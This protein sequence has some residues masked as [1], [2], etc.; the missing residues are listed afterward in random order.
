MN[1][2]TIIIS[3]AP[4]HMLLTGF[5]LIM[6]WEMISKLHNN[7]QYQ[8]KKIFSII[9]NFMFKENIYFFQAISIVTISM[10]LALWSFSTNYIAEP[11][12]G[13][14]SVTPLTNLLVLI[15]L[16]L[17]IPSI[18]FA[19]N[20]HSSPRFYLL[21]IA[22]VYGAT[23]IPTADSFVSLFLSIEMTAIPVYALVIMPSNNGKLRLAAE[24]AL[25]Y[26]IIGSIATSTIL[27]GIAFF[28]GSNSS[29]S[30]ALGEF[31]SLANSLNSSS[32]D[33][34]I[35]I[36]LSITFLL[37][38][39]FIKSAI[40]PFHTWSPDAYG[41]SS[42]SVTAFMSTVIK[43]SVFL[44]ALKLFAQVN[45]TSIFITIIFIFLLFSILWGNFAAIYQTNFRRFIGYTSIAHA[46][47]LFYAFLGDAGSERYLAISYYTIVYGLAIF[48]A[49]LSLPYNYSNK[50]SSNI[51][52]DD[53]VNLK[54]LFYQ[55]PFSA[56]MLMI[57]MLSLAGL[58]PFP[59]FVGKFLIFK[60]VASAGLISYAVIGLLASFTGLYVYLRITQLIFNKENS[61]QFAKK[62]IL[63][64]VICSIC[65]L[66]MLYLLI[67]PQTYFQLFN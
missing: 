57:S 51:Q 20:E 37:L 27:L 31:I 48:I 14:F 22:S 24:A 43:F 15:V 44:A 19:K 4:Q 6:L 32:I 38:F 34:N 3:F 11:F 28:I 46:G 9:P 12:P 50:N 17:V 63:N 21:I 55:S 18:L 65:I 64:N 29:I 54:G 40:A 8:N 25:K 2:S 33:K 7:S 56:I 1:W 23:I 66:I 42:L 67:F 61:N 49:F 45:F 16:L 53:L 26:L 10:I 5:L 36:I 60:N 39:L 58:P 35:L 52:I 30:L 62:P 47:Y 13:Q 59:G 41:S